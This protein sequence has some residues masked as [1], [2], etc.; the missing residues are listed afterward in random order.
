VIHAMI[1][2]KLSIV[3]SVFHVF[4]TKYQSFARNV[5]LYIDQFTNNYHPQV[6]YST[7]MKACHGTSTNTSNCI[8]R[9]VQSKKYHERS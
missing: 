2:P 9:K 3:W 8:L 6:I 1:L 7:T 5:L 4:H